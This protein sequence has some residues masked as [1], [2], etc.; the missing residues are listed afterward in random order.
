MAGRL[1]SEIRDRR[2]LAYAASSFYDPMKEPGVLV[3]YLGTAPENVDS[4]EQALAR[5]IAR[6][7]DQPIAPA[8]LARA[9]NYLLGKYDMDRRTNERRAWYEAYY[10]LEN[11][12]NYPARYRR[13]VEAVGVADVQRVARRYLGSYSTVILRA[14]ASPGR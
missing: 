14:P 2:G 8:E 11:V 3:L 13:A 4:A 5:E 7:R 9:K 6:I 1:F 10:A 12:A